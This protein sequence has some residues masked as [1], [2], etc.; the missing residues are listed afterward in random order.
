LTP[1]ARRAF[2]T[3]GDFRFGATVAL[4]LG[5][6]HEIQETKAMKPKTTEQPKRTAAEAA[7]IAR[8]KAGQDALAARMEER[9]EMTEAL[10]PHQ[11]GTRSR[12][13]GIRPDA[14]R[15]HHLPPEIRA[16]LR[17]RRPVIW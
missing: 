11:F 5:F 3:G 2:D 13:M 7:T 12:V 9:A 4:S 16:V 1:A 17:A 8:L 15:A 14:L 10:N 6:V